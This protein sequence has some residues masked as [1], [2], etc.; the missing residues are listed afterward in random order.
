MDKKTFFENFVEKYLN[1]T[2]DVVQY[3]MIMYIFI[4]MGNF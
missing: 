4:R 2:Q 3:I 1:Q